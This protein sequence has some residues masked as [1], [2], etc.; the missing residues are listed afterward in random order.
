M[1]ASYF[2]LPTIINRNPLEISLANFTVKKGANKLE[3]AGE[4]VENGVSKLGGTMMTNVT[5]N[6]ESGV[7][8]VTHDNEE[9]I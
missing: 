6:T 7:W 5:N 8:T 3:R 2:G 1:N 4:K 9:D